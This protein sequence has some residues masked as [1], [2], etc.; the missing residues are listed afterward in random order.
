MSVG[1]QEQYLGAWNSRDGRQV[2]EWVTDDCVYEDV[3]LGESHKGRSEIS[4]FVDG[5]AVGFSDDYHFTLIDGVTIEDSYYMEWVMRGT[6]NG[7]EGPVPATGKHFEIR[8]VS[9]GTRRGER[10]S[11]NRDYWDMATFLTQIGALPAP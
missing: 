6:H 5:I 2:A 11:A 9:V 4:A 8:G 10:I 3:T 7:T 1:W